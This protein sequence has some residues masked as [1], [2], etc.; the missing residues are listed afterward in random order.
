MRADRGL[1][2]PRERSTGRTGAVTRPNGR[3]G[4]GVCPSLL[5]GQRPSQ[6]FHAAYQLPGHLG[7]PRWRTD[8]PPKRHAMKSENNSVRW[9]CLL[10]GM[11]AAL[12][13]T[14]VATGLVLSMWAITNGEDEVPR[15]TLGYRIFD[16]FGQPFLIALACVAAGRWI[17]PSFK[18]RV[19]W[20]SGAILAI[21]LLSMLAL[22]KPEGTS[23]GL[24][25]VL[26]GV[27]GAVT[28][29]ASR[30]EGETFG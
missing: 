18:R 30:F 4:V 7:K 20:I 9:F 10:P 11:I 1:I 15:Q 24:L 23:A 13:L 26:A 6:S 22:P 17:A 21:L 14:R 3:G 8:E 16:S 25:W 29:A 5:G 19:G 2:A 12:I 28:G 27:A